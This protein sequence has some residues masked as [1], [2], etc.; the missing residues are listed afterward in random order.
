MGTNFNNDGIMLYEAMATLFLCQAFGR[1]LTLGQQLSVELK[2]NQR[3]AGT[4]AARSRR[5]VRG[6]PVC[7]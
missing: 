2:T 1:E 3:I 5:R 4:I 7:G 6:R